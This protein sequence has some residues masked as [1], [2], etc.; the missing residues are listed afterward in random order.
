MLQKHYW[1]C[2]IFIHINYLW[3]LWIHICFP[4]LHINITNLYN[5]NKGWNYSGTISHPPSPAEDVTLPRYLAEDVSLSLYSTEDT[6]TDHGLGKGATPSPCSAWEVTTPPMF[7]LN[8]APCSCSTED[9]TLPPCSSEDVA[10]APCSAEDIAPSPCITVYVAS[11][12]RFTEDVA[13]PLASRKTLLPPFA[14]CRTLFPLLLCGGCHFLPAMLRILLLIDLGA[15]GRRDFWLGCPG[16]PLDHISCFW[17]WAL[18]G[19]WCRTTIPNS[20][21]ISPEPCLNHI[22][23]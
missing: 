4:Y 13:P 7:A 17:S 14:S 15:R 1:L 23:V 12:S 3:L 10:P 18:R 21:C 16:P 2:I 8:F 11:P 22:V 20:P 9:V 5:S 19:G 6:I